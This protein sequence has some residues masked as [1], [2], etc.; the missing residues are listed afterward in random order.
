L[1]ALLLKALSYHHGRDR[2]VNVE[3]ALHVVFEGIK[4]TGLGDQ[5]P[6]RGGIVEVCVHRLSAEAKGGGD[7]ANRESLMGQV[8][9]VKDGASVHHRLLRGIGG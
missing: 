9:D 3:Q 6:V 8:M 1:E 2:G 5:R 4:L 7:L